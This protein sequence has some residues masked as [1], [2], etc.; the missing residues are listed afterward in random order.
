[1]LE[2]IIRSGKK[3]LQ[4]FGLALSLYACG[5]T[6]IVVNNYLGRDGGNSDDI[7]QIADAGNRVDSVSA[8][9]GTDGQYDAGADT[10]VPRLYFEDNDG[11]GYG[12]T[13]RPDL[14]CEGEQPGSYVSLPGDCDDTN[15]S[16]WERLPVYNDL[17]RDG[18][19]NGEL[20][21]ACLGTS[22]PDGYAINRLDCNDEETEIHPGAPEICDGIDNDCYASTV[23]GS[24]QFAALN[25][26]QFGVCFGSQKT[27]E[28]GEWQDNYSSV[29]GYEAGVE[30]TCDYAD[31]NCNGTEDEGLQSV[32]Y[33]D[34]DS[35][36][37][38][39]LGDITYTCL[40]L[41]EGYVTNAEDCQDDN[42]GINPAA[43]ELCDGVDNN[44]FGGID[45]D[46]AVGAVCYNGLGECAR[47]GNSVCA[48]D[49]LSSL[50]DA[51]PGEPV[52][53]VCGGLDND[54][55]GEV[56]C[57]DLEGRIVFRSSRGEGSEIYV[58]NANGSGQTNLTNSTGYND[59]PTWS[60]D[61]T[62]ISFNSY[63][64]G[65][66]EIYV[67]NA[68]GSEQTNL[69]NSSISE[70][71]PASWSPDS[72]QIG[73]DSGYEI[74][75]VNADGSGDRTNLT[76]TGV[77]SGGYPLGYN[78]GPA[79]SPDGTKIAFISTR[80]ESGI[81]YG[82]HL[83]VMNADG[84]EQTRL[85]GTPAAYY[86][87]GN[88]LA[89]SPDGTKIAFLGEGNDNISD[90]YIVNSDGTGET[91]LTNEDEADFDP[92]WSPDSTRIAFTS[93]REANL[94]V[95]VM[96]ADGSNQINLTNNPY[97]DRQPTWSPDG[98]KIAFMSERDENREIYVMDADGSNPRNVTYYSVAGSEDDSDDEPEWGN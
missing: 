83:Y 58:M 30:A 78:W 52:E 72:L 9:S 48:A 28:G 36:G 53:G 13:D 54:C 69:T 59:F 84:S 67:M 34:L 31:N 64:D 82:N 41:L 87:D 10:C 66:P 17:D 37:F 56:D 32:F 89:W 94:E 97:I 86:S 45:D 8:D 62:R 14:F 44:C 11:D 90:I 70:W 57:S 26:I 20:V 81:Y 46:F 76:N 55:D 4:T 27:C 93:Y 79:W 15:N 92:D 7:A 38:G 33:R 96:D 63:R 71:R 24:G 74:Y 80:Y 23:D 19:G 29:I 43:L 98:T 60:P 65:N 2:N 6:T 85:T 1:M 47:A 5:D 3:A 16:V 35:D 75:V 39:N 95:Y 91:N 22:I 21:L 12:R 25:S 68:D 50:C 42:A 61:G 18:Y 51:V 77:D 49:G 88:L 73:F 40:G